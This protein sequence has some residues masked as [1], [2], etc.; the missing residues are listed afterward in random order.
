MI[1]L[2]KTKNDDI[3]TIKRPLLNETEIGLI[4]Q[5]VGFINETDEFTFSLESN[6]TT[7]LKKICFKYLNLS[8]LEGTI[9]NMYQLL[10]W[11]DEKNCTF[12]KK[13]STNG[14][15]DYKNLKPTIPKI[16]PDIKIIGIDHLNND[17][18]VDIHIEVKCIPVNGSRSF[19]IN[20]KLFKEDYDQVVNRKSDIAIFVSPVY[21][22][23]KYLN[24]FIKI[25]SKNIE[26]FFISYKNEIDEIT[27]LTKR[28]NINNSNMIII[29]V[30]KTSFN[31]LNCI[32][33]SK[34]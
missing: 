27:I 7:F 8:I 15:W 32:L 18:I 21:Q 12:I 25:D 31:C 11:D 30:F 4:Y 28:F 19:H 26:N 6:F 24:P 13:Q 16:N 10:S 1:D 33:S 3:N 9:T 20:E 14:K 29:I 23:S 22:Y 34:K 5:L 17:I 2:T